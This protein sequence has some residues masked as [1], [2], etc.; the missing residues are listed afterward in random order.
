MGF[1]IPN[2]F[3]RMATFISQYF[4][5][6]WRKSLGMVRSSV[7][8]ISFQLATCDI[9]ILCFTKIG[10]NDIE[11]F[12][13]FRRKSLS[14]LLTKIE[15]HHPVGDVHHHSHIVFHQDTGGLPP[16]LFIDIQNK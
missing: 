2:S 8:S 5:E 12:L 14:D 9:K 11:V 10:L 3:S 16:L 6:D 7:I 15:G 4:F 13:Y 1:Q